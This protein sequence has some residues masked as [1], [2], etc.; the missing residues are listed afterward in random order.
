MLPSLPFKKGRAVYLNR[1][2]PERTKKCAFLTAI[3]AFFALSGSALLQAREVINSMPANTSETIK[4]PEPV[5]DSKT[6]IEQALL[7]RRSVRS[8]TDSPLTL[9]DVS[10]L[11]WSAQGVTGPRGLRTAPSAGALYPL[12]IY[13]VAGN[14]NALP[15][16]V[17]HYEAE[18]H[19]LVRIVSGDKRSVL[20]AAALGQPSVRNAAAVI[21]IAAV[22]ER[23]TVKYGMRGMQYVHMES[24]H[25]AQNV[26]LQAAPL[27][28]GTVVIGAFQD[29]ELKKVLKMPDREEP[30]YVMPVG[31]RK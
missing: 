6:S 21:V 23:T 7:Q 29:A 31:R 12:E 28:L 9:A 13:I 2:I 27:N 14:I 4:L 22:Y 18:R 3:I 25:A 24:G 15:A 5:Q 8:F 26:S 16:G 19:E 17:Y 30:L 1:F 20:C 11:L 10:Q